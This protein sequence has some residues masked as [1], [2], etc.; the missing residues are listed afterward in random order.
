MAGER[1]RCVGAL[2]SV[3]FAFARLFRWIGRRSAFT[4]LRLCR[5]YR[6]RLG[7]STNFVFAFTLGFHL[8]AALPPIQD[9][10]RQK[11]K[12]RFCFYARFSLVC[13]SAAN[14]GCASAKAQ[15]LFLLLR[16]AFTYLRLCRQYRMRLGKSTNFVFAFTLG[17]HYICSRQE[18]GGVSCFFIIT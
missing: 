6:M 16:S 10:P 5:Q 11:H 3:A 14:I 7:K 9:A 1:L 12:L 13:G 8:F 15:T 4:C 2:R 18:A 17:F